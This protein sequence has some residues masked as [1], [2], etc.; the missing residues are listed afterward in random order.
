L[1]VRLCPFLHNAAKNP[2]TAA[3]ATS[4]FA[5]TGCVNKRALGVMH[6]MHVVHDFFFAW[7]AKKQRD[8]TATANTT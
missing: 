4:H 6:F 8:D 1:E 7:R 5:T 3:V 2:Q